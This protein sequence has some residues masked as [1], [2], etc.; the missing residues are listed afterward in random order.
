MHTQN[1]LIVIVTIVTIVTPETLSLCDFFLPVCFL[2]I[3][4]R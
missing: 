4:F 2:A 1:K 3:F